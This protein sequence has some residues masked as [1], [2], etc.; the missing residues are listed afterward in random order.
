MYSTA[1][2]GKVCLYM[3]ACLPLSPSHVFSQCCVISLQ[4]RQVLLY[5]CCI[6]LLLDV[7]ECVW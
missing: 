7:C 5:S 3:P 4:L 6:L 2:D 1:G